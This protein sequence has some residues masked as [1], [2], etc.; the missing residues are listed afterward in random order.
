LGR[1]GSGG[2]CA[3][4]PGSVAMR[5]RIARML[6]RNEQSCDA[7]L[8]SCEA[9]S[10]DLM[11]CARPTLASSSSVVEPVTWPCGGKAGVGRG[12]EGV[13][14]GGQTLKCDAVC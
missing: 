13:G 14:K 11:A 1:T 10:E 3:I 4:I 12:W 8:L 9:P 2:I 6:S 7:L 5:C